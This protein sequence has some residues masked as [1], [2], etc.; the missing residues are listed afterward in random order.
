MNNQALYDVADSLESM[1]KQLRIAAKQVGENR[2][3]V[4]ET[5][6]FRRE[7]AF[8]ANW[9]NRLQVAVGGET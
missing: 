5:D 3:E 1:A 9:V 8:T 2:V 6:T 7:H 4:A